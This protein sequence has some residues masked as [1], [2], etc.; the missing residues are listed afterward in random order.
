MNW[1][2]SSQKLRPGGDTLETAQQADSLHDAAEGWA[3]LKI[4][5]LLAASSFSRR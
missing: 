5:L 2:R 4:G 3:H 1:Q